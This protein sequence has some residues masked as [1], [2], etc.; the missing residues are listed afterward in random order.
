MDVGVIKGV[1]VGGSIVGLGVLIGII[2]VGVDLENGVG[3]GTTGVGVDPGAWVEKSLPPEASYHQSK[4]R[5]PS[6]SI[7]TGSI[8]PYI[9]SC[10]KSKMP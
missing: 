4:Q 8:P 2:G 1:D 3:D 6:L 10:L 7:S 9:P 5:V